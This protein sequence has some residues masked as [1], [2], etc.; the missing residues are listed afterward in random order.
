MRDI[1][2]WRHWKVHRIS[3]MNDRQK[4]I[5]RRV[6][7]ISAVSVEQGNLR[8]SMGKDGTRAFLVLEMYISYLNISRLLPFGYSGNSLDLQK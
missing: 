5:Q 8:E 7:S 3:D 6:K 4:K 1:K 2:N